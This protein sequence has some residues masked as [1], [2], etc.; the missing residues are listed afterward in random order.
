VANYSPALV[1]DDT[2]LQEWEVLAKLSAIA[3][4]QGAEL[5]AAMVDAFAFSASLQHTL[6]DPI[7]PVHGRDP[8]EIMAALGNRTGPERYVDFLLRAGPYGDLFGEHPDGLTL[9]ALEASPHGIDLGA[10]QSR[11]PEALATTTGTVD[12]A[13]A[14]ILADLPR[15]EATIGSTNGGFL[16][17][18]RRHVRSNNSWMHNVDVLI[19]GRDRCTLLIH[20]EDAVSIGVAD[21]SDA[22]V[23][24]AA[25]KVVVRAEVTEDIMRGVVSLPH[26]WGHDRHGVALSVAGTRP[27]V[28][29]NILTDETDIDPLS[30]NAT[31]NAIPVTVAAAAR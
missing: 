30:G 9:A 26:G 3:A 4:G 7:S 19:K 28:N 16:L 25:G 24:S 29:S 18:G 27:G 17:I 22:E 21:G 6:D 20:P 23:A 1:P 13:P 5:P 15:L 12:L 11:L 31:L 2:G 14:P 8:D 10:L